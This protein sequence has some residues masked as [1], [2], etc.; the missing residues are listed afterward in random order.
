MLSRHCSEPITGNKQK[1]GDLAEKTASC[2]SRKKKK[3]NVICYTRFN[4]ECVY[5]CASV[6]NPLVPRVLSEQ[7]CISLRKTRDQL[8]SLIE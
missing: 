3:V 7:V 6:V 5:S 4:I 8:S 1:E 2:V